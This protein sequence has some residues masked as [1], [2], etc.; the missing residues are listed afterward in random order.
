MDVGMNETGNPVLKVVCT[1]RGGHGERT[2]GALAWAETEAVI[3]WSEGS[4]RRPCIEYRA[5]P[6]RVNGKPATSLDLGRIVFQCPACRRNVP[7]KVDGLGVLFHEG[8]P[9]VGALDISMLG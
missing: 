8:A 1:G 6:V 5:R 7:R 4:R 2:L 9:R 3:V